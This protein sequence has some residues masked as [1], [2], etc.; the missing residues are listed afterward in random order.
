M[1]TA[2]PNLVILTAEIGENI[3]G[4]AIDADILINFAVANTDVNQR[5]FVPEAQLVVTGKFR[6]G[7]EIATIGIWIS[8]IVAIVSIPAPAPAEIAHSAVAT[9]AESATDV[10]SVV[11]PEIAAGDVE[12]TAPSTSEPTSKPTRAQKAAATR[13]AKKTKAKA[14]SVPC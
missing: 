6:L 1:R 3:T 13:A 11:E 9:G 7:K 8:I 4:T 14:E 2:I 5:L 10:E 12:S